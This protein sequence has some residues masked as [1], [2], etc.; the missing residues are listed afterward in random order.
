MAARGKSKEP[1]SAS[2]LGVSAGLGLPLASESRAR[3][4]RVPPNARELGSTVGLPSLDLP[5]DIAMTVATTQA[6]RLRLTPLI[7][8]PL[9]WS[10]GV[11]LSVVR[12]GIPLVHGRRRVPCLVVR[13]A[14][15]Q[16]EVVMRLTSE[17]RIT[18]GTAERLALGLESHGSAVLAVVRRRSPNELV[19]VGERS[20]GA[21]LMERWPDAV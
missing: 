12:S 17:F 3:V 8:D 4:Y 15:K 7:G 9:P 21:L 14:G 11:T 5:D 18:L 20:L 19:L 10:V 16:D 2:A 6:G 13:P 1:D